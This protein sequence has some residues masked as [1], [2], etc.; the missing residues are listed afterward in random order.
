MPPRYRRPGR[1]IEPSGWSFHFDCEELG[2]VLGRICPALV[3]IAVPRIE[4]KW[5]L[6][7]DQFVVGNEAIR[8]TVSTLDHWTKPCRVEESNKQSVVVFVRVARAQVLQ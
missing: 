6:R 7:I 2:P 8:V 5:F 3:S 1:D 4:S